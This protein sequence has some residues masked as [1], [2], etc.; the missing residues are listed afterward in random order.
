MTHVIWQS[1]TLQAIAQLQASIVFRQQSSNTDM[2]ELLHSPEA[3]PL[4]C[5]T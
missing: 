2:H 1:Q 4:T 3:L 5:A